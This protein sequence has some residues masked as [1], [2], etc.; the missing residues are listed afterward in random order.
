ME[1]IINN[2]G[3]I[4]KDNGYMIFASSKKIYLENLKLKEIHELYIHKS[5]TRYVHIYK[6]E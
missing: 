6:K 3:G 1:D 4:L 2:L 5:L